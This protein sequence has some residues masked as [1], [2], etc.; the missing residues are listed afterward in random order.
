M[1]ERDHRALRIVGDQARRLELL[2]DE[3]LDISR[4]ETGLFSVDRA[5]MDLAALSRRVAEELEPTLQAHTLA[6]EVP[7]VPVP[8]RGDERRLEQVLQNLL[9]NA[10]KYSPD[11][12]Q[13]GLRITPV[14]GYARLEIRDEGLGIPEAELEHLFQRFYRAANVDHVRI[15]GF[16]LGLYLVQQIVSRHDGTV[17]VTSTEGQGSTFAIS[18]PLDA[19]QDDGG[20]IGE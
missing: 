20:T 2:V 5:P 6:L 14:D 8:I 1:N 3:M 11:G 9:G 17:E 13:I 10:I 7:E 4:I 19:G 12:G 16:G 15:S 18:L